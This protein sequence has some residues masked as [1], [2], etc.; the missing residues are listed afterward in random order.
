MRAFAFF[1]FVGCCLVSIS[2]FSQTPKQIEADLLKSFKQIQ[3]W[4]EKRYEDT[5]YHSEYEDSLDD[6]NKVFGK[7]LKYYAEKY[8]TTIM[9]NFALLK[10]EYLGIST[11]SDGLFRIYSWDT[12]EGGTMRSYENVFQYKSGNGTFAV[13]DTPGVDPTYYKILTVKSNPQPIYAANF[14]YTESSRYHDEGIQ[15]FKIEGT[16]LNVQYKAIN[17]KS[18]LHNQISYEYDLSSVKDFNNIPSII[19]N[20]SQQ[21]IK[22]P[23]VDVKG[24]FT[25]GSITYKFTGKYFERVKN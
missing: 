22:L 20:S 12:E 6:A 2:A 25:K 23:I 4:N 15:I 8:P 18:G 24:R 7:K 14:L 1:V 19:F 11:S 16:K 3:Y 10:K 13:L 17:T 21:T 9:Q 5:T